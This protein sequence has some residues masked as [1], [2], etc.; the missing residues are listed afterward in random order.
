MSK[1]ILV[2]SDNH[3]GH[4]TGLTPPPFQFKEYGKSKTRKNKWAGMQRDMWR[5][6]KKMMKRYEP[7]DIGFHLGDLVEG[8][9][10]RSGGVELITSDMSEQADIAT[11]VCDSVRLH[12]SKGFKWYGAS[13]TPYHVS[14]DGDDWDSIVAERS[15]FEEFGTHTWVDV[16]GCIF[17]LKHKVGSSSVPHGRHTAIAKERLW[18][19]LW[20]ERQPQAN[21]VLRGHTHYHAYCGGADWLAMVCP[22]LQGWTK[23]GSAQCSG[24]VDFGI[25]VIDVDNKGRYEWTSDTIVI[26]S[27][28]AKAVKA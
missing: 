12:A 9:G 19:Q 27:Q 3:G 14:S 17:D 28:K 6:F 24:T 1:R 13:G 7:F 20:G 11:G 8:K 16:N 15:G 26:E 2:I 18:N 10:K 5:E 23:Y 21:V 22:S 25:I 4:I